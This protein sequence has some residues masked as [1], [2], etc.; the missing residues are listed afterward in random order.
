MRKILM[1]QIFCMVIFFLPVLLEA[2]EVPREAFTAAESF[3]HNYLIKENSILA[4]CLSSQ[5]VDASAVNSATLGQPYCYYKS[6]YDDILSYESDRSYFASLQTLGYRFPILVTDKI[7]GAVKVS[8][9]NYYPGWTSETTANR[10][11]HEKRQAYKIQKGYD[12]ALLNVANRLRFVLLIKGDSLFIAPPGE[13][14]ASLFQKVTECQ[15]NDFV[16][17]VSAIPGLKERA[18][19]IKRA[20]EQPSKLKPIETIKEEQ[21]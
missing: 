18:R 3:L 4:S 7:Y 5:G 20:V 8:S 13:S 9:N 2:Q 14:D 16:P 15:V 1:L 10:F 17:L 6:G 19:E 11:I 21:R 12:L